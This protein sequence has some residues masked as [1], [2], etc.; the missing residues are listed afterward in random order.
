[1]LSQ[2][3]T[4]TPNLELSTMS[5]AVFT[6][7][8]IFMQRL[9]LLSIRPSVLQLCLLSMHLARTLAA[10]LSGALKLI[11]GQLFGCCSSVT[12]WL[13]IVSRFSLTQ[14]QHNR[15]QLLCLC[16][17]QPRFGYGVNAPL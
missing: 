10:D 9:C 13:P 15:T 1:M 3:Q 12:L 17:A 2:Y 16:P 5:Q 4:L 8:R 11:P 7:L 14:M 6:N